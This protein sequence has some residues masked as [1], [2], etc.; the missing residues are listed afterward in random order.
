MIATL[1]SNKPGVWIQAVVPG[2]GKFTI[3]LNRATSG[4]TFVGYLVIN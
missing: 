3:Y 4:A 2:S 1:Q